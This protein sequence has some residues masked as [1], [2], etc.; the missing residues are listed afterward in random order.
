MGTER[1]LFCSATILFPK[2]YDQISFALRL[3]EIWLR[4]RQSRS[5]QALVSR[6]KLVDQTY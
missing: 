6:L 2:V 4:S 1:F 3:S 5:L